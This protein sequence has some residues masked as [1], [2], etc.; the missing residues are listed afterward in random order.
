MLTFRNEYPSVPHRLPQFNTSVPHKD[1][2]FSAPK[3]PS[4]PHQKPLTSTHPS[5]KNC[6][7]RRGFRCETEGFCV[8][9]RGF[10]V[11]LMGF[12]CGIDEFWVLKRCG[13]QKFK[14][15]IKKRQ[16]NQI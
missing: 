1:H 2:T 6:V 11:E 15:G 14:P 13:P 3:S 5:D 4:V 7:E 8:E 16:K 10:G 12:W 9:V